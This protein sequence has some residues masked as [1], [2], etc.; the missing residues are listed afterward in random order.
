M[1]LMIKGGK[2]SGI[3]IPDTPSR[4]ESRKWKSQDNNFFLDLVYFQLSPINFLSRFGSVMYYSEI[5]L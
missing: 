3:D 1:R 2:N 5:D 4:R